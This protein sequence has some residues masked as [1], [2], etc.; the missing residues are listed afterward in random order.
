M[1]TPHPTYKPGRR[2]RQGDSLVADKMRHAIRKDFDMGK[3]LHGMY[4]GKG[5]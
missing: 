1:R 4:D 3:T 5:H 2:L